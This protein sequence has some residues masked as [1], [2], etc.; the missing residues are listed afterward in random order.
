MEKMFMEKILYKQKF[1]PYKSLILIIKVSRKFFE[2][3]DLNWPCACDFICSQIFVLLAYSSLFYHLHVQLTAIIYNI[4]SAFSF[5]N[6]LYIYIY[7]DKI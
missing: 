4:I 3:N 1:Q 5:K 2:W 6:Y 7:I